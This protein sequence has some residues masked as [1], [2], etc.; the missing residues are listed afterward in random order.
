MMDTETFYRELYERQWELD[1]PNVVLDLRDIMVEKGVTLNYQNLTNLREG[2]KP[3]EP[4]IGDGCIIR[5]GTVIY[6]GCVL[7][8]R[9][10]VNHNVVLREFTEVGDHT[11][12]GTGVVVEGYTKIG[13]HVNIFTQC[14]ITAKMLIEDDVF[15]GPNVTTTNGKRPTWRRP[16]LT[17]IEKG[18]TI[19]RGA[20]IGGGV[21]ILPGVEIGEGAVIGAGA[22]VT[23][24][25]PPFKVAVGIPAKVI[26][27]VPKEER[28]K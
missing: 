18:P 7:G 2:Y 14:H 13:K 5:S 22:V 24:D 1:F 15:M 8:D 4:I 17:G 27:D 9:V 28:I 12:I 10:I 25:I 16:H 19:R 20:I 6:P 3:V 21:T 11:K 26:K 23:K